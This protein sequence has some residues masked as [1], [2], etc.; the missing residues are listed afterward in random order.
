MSPAA[1]VRVLGVHFDPHLSFD[2]HIS[3]CLSSCFSALRQIRSVKRSL[4]RP[5]LISVVRSLVISRLDYCISVLSGVTKRQLQRLQSVLNASAR[6]FFSSTRF[7]HVSQHLKVLQFLPVKYRIEYRLSVLAHNCLHDR[8]PSYLSSDF[9]LLSNC[10]SRR[11][12]RSS[13]SSLVLQPRSRHPTLGGRAFPVAA[14]K[15]WN[16]LPPH[17]ASIVNISDFKD[18]ALKYFLQRSF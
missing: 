16:S 11:R 1:S 4:S 13:S 8:A 17:L 5:I 6:L 9:H 14:A 15:V 7:S 2:V 18:E 3:R 10:P 12:L